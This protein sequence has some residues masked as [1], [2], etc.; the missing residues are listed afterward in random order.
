[1]DDL[2]TFTKPWKNM[3]VFHLRNDLPN[4]EGAD[5]KESGCGVQLPDSPAHSNNWFVV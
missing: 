4:Y 1:M 3:R 5:K 2:K